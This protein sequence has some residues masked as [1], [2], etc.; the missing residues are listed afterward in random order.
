[1]KATFKYIVTA[2][3]VCAALVSCQKDNLAGNTDDNPAV[4]NARVIEVHFGTAT[5]SALAVEAGLTPSFVN[6]D[7]IMASNG[8]SKEECSISVD[9]NYNASFTTSLT[10]DLTAIYPSTAAKLNG[11]AIEGV[12]VPATQDGTFAK[13]NIAKATIASDATSATFDNQTSLLRFY[14]DVSIGVKSIT[15]TAGG[16]ANIADGSKTI[17]VDPEGDVTL[18]TVTDD[19]GGRICYVSVLPGTF[20]SLKFTSVTTTQKD[21]TNNTVERTASNVTLATNKI[22]NAFIPYY[23]DLGTAGKWGYCNVGAFLPEDAGKYFAWGETSGHYPDGQGAFAFGVNNGGFADD[24]SNCPY[25][26]GDDKFTKYML[27]GYNDNW[28]G[29]GA[30]DN[31]TVLAAVD[32][33]AT[34]IWGNVWRMPEITEF[35]TLISSYPQTLQDF[36]SG[37]SFGTSPYSVFLPAAGD[38]NNT[39]LEDKGSWGIYWSSSLNTENDPDPGVL[40]G[41]GNGNTLEFWFDPDPNVSEYIFT[42]DVSFE[43]RYLGCSIRPVKIVAPA[44]IPNP[45]ETDEEEDIL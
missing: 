22:Y 9:N 16:N 30:P 24:F 29:T 33:A 44:S 23:I 18:D 39:E 11:N 5:K 4:G 15:I 31:L 13:A 45:T 28:G 19:P 12:I 8:T 37:F 6:G 25:Y 43:A 27:T 42:P 26:V 3:A 17:V 41:P 36:H 32:D 20:T 2:F 35:Q 1:M 34:A 21:Y 40:D 7:K 14:V 10:G 38:G